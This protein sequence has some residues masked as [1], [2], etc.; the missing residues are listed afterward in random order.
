LSTDDTT[1]SDVDPEPVV[2]QVGELRVTP[3]SV[4]LTD[5]TALTQITVISSAAGPVKY[6]VIPSGSHLVVAKDSGEFTGKTLIDVELNTTGLAGQQLAGSVLIKSEL[7]DAV[8]NL[9]V[10][11]G[12]S[13]V[14][15]GSLTYELGNLQLGKA[16]L[17]IAIYDDGAGQAVG[18]VDAGRSLLFPTVGGEPAAG[19]GT[20][21]GTSVSL[22]VRQVFAAN[23]GGER[24]VLQR[25]LGRDF[26]LQ[27]ERDREGT[28]EGT[29]SE[30][31][32]GLTDQP[33]E[34]RG[35]ST[36]VR[37]GD[38]GNEVLSSPAPLP[39]P[40]AV[41]AR[42]VSSEELRKSP[43][44]QV[45]EVGAVLF[46]FGAGA[47]APAGVTGLQCFDAAAQLYYNPLFQ[48]LNGALA[49]VNP[50]GNIADTC[51][52]EGRLSLLDYGAD[53]NN[54]KCASWRGVG[55]ALTEI[56]RN[57]NTSDPPA[58]AMVNA[59]LSR[60]LA[61]PLL[62]AQDRTLE[63]L[64]ASFREGAS[65]QTT[66]LDDARGNLREALIFS[67]QPG[68]LAFLRDGVA[69]AAQGDARAADPV[70]R[71][72][73]GL[74]SV[75]R[76]LDLLAQL[77]EE[78][79]VRDLA[80]AR[81][82][83]ERQSV[84]ERVQ[85]RAVLSLFE[86]ASV[87]A[88][89][90]KWGGLPNSVASGIDGIL[91]PQGAA[92]SSIRD[93]AD[94][95]GVAPG[96][97]ALVFDPKRPEPTNFEQLLTREASSIA[98]ADAAETVFTEREREFE[99]SQ[100]AL[101]VELEQTQGGYDDRLLAICGEGF[102][103]A[104][105]ARPSANFRCGEGGK[106]EIGVAQLGIQAAHNEQLAALT[107][108]EG[109]G[110][111]IR[112]DW[113]ALERTQAERG[114][115]IALI[116]RQGNQLVGYAVAEG[117][118]NVA[119]AVVE[120]APKNIFDWGAAVTTPIAAG[121]EAARATINVQRQRLQNARDLRFQ[122]EGRAIE[123]I[124]GMASIQR[125]VIDMEE[126]SVAIAQAKLGIE[127]ARLQATNL[128]EEARR[129]LQARTRNLER[130]SGSSLRDPADR[131]LRDAAA[132]DAIS[133]RRAAQISLFKLGRALE[134]E[135]N[136]PLGAAL[137]RAVNAALNAQARTNLQLCYSDI[138]TR[139]ATEAG[140]P[141]EFKTS[142]SARE[143]LEVLGDR[144][145]EVTGE[146]LTRAELFRRQLLRNE[147]F[148]VS[149]AVTLTFATRLDPGNAL[150]SSNVCDDKIVSVRAQLVGD[151]LGDNEAEIHLGV[152][153]DGVLR[154]CNGGALNT[155][156]LRSSASQTAVVQA[157]V[158]S[159]GTAA[160]STTLF[161][162][163]V[164]RPSWT[165][166]IPAGNAAPTNKDLVLTGLEDI[167]LEITHSA[168]PVQGETF[169]VDT[170]CL[171]SIGN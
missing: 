148:D 107:R 52:A 154:T 55:V 14:Y 96:E 63:G 128:F 71:N 150:W 131:L 167:I 129:I 141:Q 10:K 24:N 40:P 169:S 95:L 72:Y 19:V 12:M 68:V 115:T 88:V 35:K 164:A 161:G 156:A 133:K 155:W 60:L 125:Q 159:F 143:M 139:Y 75:A 120:Q 163:A 90:E 80:R 160:A 61:A 37:V 104:A 9:P 20:A 157:G 87:L 124:N 158:N 84:L 8:V 21:R 83:G 30:R 135:I 31:L 27:V 13:G 43:A 22:D 44:G 97:V 6:R 54:R 28:F 162:N 166:T 74:R 105:A 89:A 144:T 153:G 4:L 73:P 101:N 62:V 41:S 99:T 94:V 45:S 170:S 5:R 48:S 51:A 59:N 117:I 47:C 113:E 81:T 121:I 7:G 114:K 127:I 91:M 16:D 64:K 98:L 106:G 18:V 149:G 145:D 165:I 126:V 147:N 36:L 66:Y 25:T 122:E 34:L 93:G 58:T 78:A 118:L 134:Y 82:E 138:L 142:V 15:E 77:D 168:L 56:I 171:G 17:R 110:K 136:T 76:A 100:E 38:L 86:V 11:V 2:K 109:M 79:A 39:L 29:F 32:Y 137:S 130:L 102:D 49:G 42:Q 53:F 123:Y 151:G 23:F 33:V 57:F 103:I 70:L 65:A 1:E 116:D 92:F 46:P 3:Q 140:I 132:V 108:M 69:T 112:V 111:K 67:M 146:E 50:I 85:A 119:K 152:G 26:A